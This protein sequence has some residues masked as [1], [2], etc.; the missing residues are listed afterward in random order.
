MDL[1]RASWAGCLFFHLELSASSS[2]THVRA[3]AASIRTESHL[4]DFGYQ[5]TVAQLI[6]SDISIY[7]VLEGRSYL[8]V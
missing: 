7:T 8:V 2:V 1:H 6:A 4:K 3:A 5:S